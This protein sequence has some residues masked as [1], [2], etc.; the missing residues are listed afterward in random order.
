VRVNQWV[1]GGCRQSGRELDDIVRAVLSNHACFLYDFFH[2]LNDPAAA[3]RLVTFD[4]AAQDM[5]DRMQEAKEGTIVVSPHLGNFDL[6]TQAAVGTRIRA[7]I[8]TLNHTS[9]AYRVQDALRRRPNIEVTPASPGALRQALQRLGTGG[10]VIT[11]VERPLPG[12]RYNPAFFGRPAPLP[13]HHV[14]LALKANVPIW[15]I[16]ARRLKNGTYTVKSSGPIRMKRYPDRQTD[17]LRNA[18]RILDVAAD[19]I[20]EAPDQWSMFYPV[21]PEA[22]AELQDVERGN[23]ATA[24]Q[25][26]QKVLDRRADL[27]HGKSSG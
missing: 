4:Q 9:G 8:I 17:I 5:L 23:S 7:Q 10:T 13:V 3:K 18:E 27:P 22:A 11:G 16:S 26:D 2:N 19:Y 1:A 12:S 6:S 25:Q 20:R 15:V 21:W 24:Q 14:Y